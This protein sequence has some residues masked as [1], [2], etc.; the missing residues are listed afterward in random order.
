[1]DYRDAPGFGRARCG[2][3]NYEKDR[4]AWIESRKRFSRYRKKNVFP[5]DHVLPADIF[6]SVIYEGGLMFT[7]KA[8]RLFSDVDLSFAKVREIRVVDD[9]K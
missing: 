1:M 6:T 2:N 4:D 7:D 8:F 3:V 9:D 5:R